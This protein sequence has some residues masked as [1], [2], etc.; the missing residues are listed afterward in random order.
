MIQVVFD[1]YYK[2]KP[3]FKTQLFTH[4]TAYNMLLVHVFWRS[5]PTIT[6]TVLTTLTNRFVD[7]CEHV[8]LLTLNFIYY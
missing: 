7:K 6:P 3:L 5:L 4:V 2:W 1:V 8:D